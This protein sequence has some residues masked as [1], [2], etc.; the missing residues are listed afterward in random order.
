MRAV[1]SCPAV[2]WRP[3]QLATRFLPRIG[4]E[5]V[6]IATLSKTMGRM[7]FHCHFQCVLPGLWP[8]PFYF[9]LRCL[10]G[11]NSQLTGPFLFPSMRCFQVDHQL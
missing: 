8:C 6:Q 9:G 10:V 3:V 5:R 4:S 11:H 1:A 2:N 7:V